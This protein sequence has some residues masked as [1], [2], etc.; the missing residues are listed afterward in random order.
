[1]AAPIGTLR[2][3]VAVPAST[4]T[5]RIWSVAYATDDSASDDRT[6]RALT[7]VRRSCTW[8]A[9]LIGCPS[10]MLRTSA[11]RLP[12]PSWARLPYIDACRVAASRRRRGAPVASR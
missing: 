7:L 2:N 6:A 10:N 9:V 3:R 1:M 4:S 11:I 8:R 12:I 5:A